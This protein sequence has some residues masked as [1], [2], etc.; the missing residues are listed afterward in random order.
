MT[1]TDAVKYFGSQRALAKACDVSAQAVS[2][3]ADDHIPMGQQYRLQILTKGK[4]M[5]DIQPKTK[6][7]AK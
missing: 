4:L 2:L 3:W 5:A 6:R 7:T 1:K